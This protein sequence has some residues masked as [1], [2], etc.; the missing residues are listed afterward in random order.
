MYTSRQMIAEWRI[1]LRVT[2][3]KMGA[4]GGDGPAM[5][6]GC[7]AAWFR[8]TAVPP[9]ARWDRPEAG[10]TFGAWSPDG[11]WVY[12]TSKA[13]GLYHIWR[14]RFPDGQPEQLTSGPTEE[15]GIAMAPDGRSFVTAVALQ[16]SS[17][18]IH[19]RAA[20][21]R[22]RCSKATP[23]TRSSPPMAR[24]FATGL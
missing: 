3:W 9:A 1:G 8:S 11:K 20:S 10:C 24:S 7:R 23:R 21:V 15:E 16:S 19:D 5:A 13:G 2:R 14:Q 12:L 18:W 22:F 6:T 4:A 17:V